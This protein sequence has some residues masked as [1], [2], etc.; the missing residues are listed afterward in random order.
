MLGKNELSRME[1]V[2]KEVEEGTGCSSGGQR[3]SLGP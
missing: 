2:G 3:D 1:Q